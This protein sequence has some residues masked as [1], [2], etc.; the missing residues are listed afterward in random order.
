MNDTYRR[1]VI[2]RYSPGSCT[3]RGFSKDQSTGARQNPLRG[4]RAAGS[5][6]VDAV[7]V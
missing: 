1:G 2:D 6:A 5:N 4:Q 7:L 3:A